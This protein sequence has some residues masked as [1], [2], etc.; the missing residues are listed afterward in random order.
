MSNAG[1]T[2]KVH[3]RGTLDDGTEFDSSYSRN[4]PLGFCCMG[5]QMIAG[6]DAAVNEME[7]GQTINIR[8]SPD[9]AYGESDPNRVIRFPKSQ[10]PNP[11]TYKVGDTVG[12]RAA[13]GGQIQAVIVEIQDDII[14]LDANHPMAGK[15]LNFEITLLSVE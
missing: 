6:F 9:E 4:Q 3:Y 13:Y 8:L 1:R 14:V 10:I 7:V 11:E 2:V 15:Y 12:L 5:G